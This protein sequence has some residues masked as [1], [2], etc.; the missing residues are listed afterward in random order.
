[1][2]TNHHCLSSSLSFSLHA[3][4]ATLTE[5]IGR[6]LESLLGRLQELRTYVL[7]VG[8]WVDC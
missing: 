4:V 3:Q 2:P 5:D 8:G 1:M 6:E 7:G